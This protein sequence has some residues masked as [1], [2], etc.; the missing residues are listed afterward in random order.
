M[1]QG[2]GCVV[3]IVDV[4]CTWHADLFNEVEQH[5]LQ[6]DALGMVLPRHTGW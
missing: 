6:P 4:E 2:H 1:S 5:Q 3:G